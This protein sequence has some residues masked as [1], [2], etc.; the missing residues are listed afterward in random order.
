MKRLVLL[1]A[2]LMLCIAASAQITL[3][4]SNRDYKQSA[5]HSNTVIVKTKA[6]VE[7]YAG[8]HGMLDFGVGPHV[9]SAPSKGPGFTATLTG[10]YEF[11]FGL[12][13]GAATGYS[14]WCNKAYTDTGRGMSDFR[15]MACLGWNIGKNKSSGFI[16]ACPGVAIG[17]SEGCAFSADVKIGYRYMI[18]P[19]LGIAV[20]TGINAILGSTLV[21]PL[22]IGI[23][24]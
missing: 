23:V 12:M 22:N 13:L 14:Y 6:E 3:S 15:L 9:Y 10:F 24:F 21:I 18:R 19:H 4:G 16:L 8:F 1:L 17:Q 20:S 5:K 11:N 2:A 7:S